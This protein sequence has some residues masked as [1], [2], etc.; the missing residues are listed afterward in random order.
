MEAYEAVQLLELK[1]GQLKKDYD[2]YFAGV[3][4]VEP[5]KLKEE[6]RRLVS[7]LSTV[8]ITN[9]GLRFKRDSLIAHYNS[10][11]QYWTRIL[12]QI[13]DGTYNRDLFKMGLKDKGGKIETPP[14]SGEAQ[15]KEAPPPARGEYSSVFNDLVSAKHRRGESA[16][17]LNY[18]VFEQNLKKQSEAIKKKYNVSR[19]DFAVE[20]KDGKVIIKA[21]PKR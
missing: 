19:V 9:T 6:V 13:E 12:R 17:V 14:S 10:Y 5:S 4:R 8:H 21:I 2:K 16:E 15:K 1:L 7:Q 20:E 11:S 3:E 18:Q